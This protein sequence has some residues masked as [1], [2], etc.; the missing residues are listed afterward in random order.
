MIGNGSYY[1]I[2][3]D[4]R[5][6]LFFSIDS[7]FCF[8]IAIHRIKDNKLNFRLANIISFEVAY[9]SIESATQE[10]YFLTIFFRHFGYECCI[11]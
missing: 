6:D 10:Y 9:H 5:F 7:D 8:Q 4:P 1:F 11:L 3:I 2:S